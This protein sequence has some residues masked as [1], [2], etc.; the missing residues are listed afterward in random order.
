[1]AA[2][3]ITPG[4]TEECDEVVG[5]EVAEAI[6]ARVAEE[7]GV[8]V[9]VE[10][11]D[12]GSVDAVVEAPPSDGKYSPGLNISVE[13]RAKASWVSKVSVELGLITPIMPSTMHA[14]GAEQ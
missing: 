3:A 2:P 14:P 10:G 6:G 13:F 12:D 7:V 5:A 4:E 9:E 11:E 8:E 1:M